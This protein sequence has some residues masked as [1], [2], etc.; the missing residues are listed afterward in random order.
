[1]PL[2]RSITNEGENRQ[3]RK[4]RKKITQSSL[5]VYFHFFLRFFRVYPMMIPIESRLPIDGIINQ[6]NCPKLLSHNIQEL[7]TPND[8]NLS[9]KKFYRRQLRNE[10]I[11]KKPELVDS[12]EE[13][14]KIESK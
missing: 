12:D 10:Q 7:L 9:E 1:M 2:L 4:H 6:E 5:I 13:A 11:R 3:I 14:T 8:V